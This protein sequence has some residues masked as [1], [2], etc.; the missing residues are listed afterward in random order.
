MVMKIGEGILPKVSIKV[1]P[2]GLKPPKNITDLIIPAVIEEGK[3]YIIETDRIISCN[4]IE[5][6]EL[7][8]YRKSK[9]TFII[10]QHGLK[11]CKLEVLEN[12]E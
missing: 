1:K 8:L 4:E 5:H 10:L 9:A 12:V 3:T 11:L 7:A 2:I 6:I